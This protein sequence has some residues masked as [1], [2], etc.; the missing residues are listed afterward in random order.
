LA[1]KVYFFRGD[2][3]VRY[4]SGRNGVEPCYPKAVGGNWPDIAQ[5][6]FGAGFDAVVNWG[7]GKA[8]LF[9]ASNYLRY[10][11]GSNTVDPGYPRPIAQ[12]WQGTDGLGIG[13]DF[14]PRL[15][16]VMNWWNGKAYLFVGN[17]YLRYDVGAGRVDPG[18]PLPLAGNWPGLAEVGF[19]TR[20]G[21]AVNWGNGRA[22]FFDLFHPDRYVGYD[23]GADHVAPGYPR[24]IAGNW[25]GLVGA[26]FAA[27]YGVY[28]AARWGNDRDYLFHKDEYVLYDRSS[29]QVDVGYPRPIAGYWAGMSEAGFS[30]GIDA[31]VKWWNGKVYLFRGAQYVRYDIPSYRVDPGYPRPITGYWPGMSEAGFSNGI[32]AA[33]KWW[34]GKVYFFRGAQYVRYDI[35]ADRVDPGYPRPITGYWPGMSEAGFSNDID[36]VVNWG[37]GKAYFFRGDQYVRYDISAHQVDPGYPRPIAGHWPGM[38]EAGF[39]NGIDAAVEL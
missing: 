6:G 21:A 37:N 26:G 10:D 20:V 14:G 18:Y 15:D 23:V 33:V 9:L 30:N 27:N 1:T 5:A 31:T 35:A 7:N 22:Y 34:N 25:P 17:R 29:G 36:A 32:D 38:S 3:Y 13:W 8:Y 4:G 11:I 28:A 19:T 39:S 24:P 12:G 2:K 16:A